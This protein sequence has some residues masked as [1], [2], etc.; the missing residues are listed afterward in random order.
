MTP[1]DVSLR[2]FTLENA[3][4]LVRCEKRSIEF[5]LCDSIRHLFEKHGIHLK[6]ALKVSERISVLT[7]ICD[8]A[9]FRIVGYSL[10]H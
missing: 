1:F 4:R 7:A 6:K 8:T 5:L 2:K 3:G 10:L 9:Q